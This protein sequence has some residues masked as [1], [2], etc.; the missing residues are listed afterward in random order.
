MG[1]LKQNSYM[2]TR[3]QLFLT[4]AEALMVAEE[5]W[6]KSIHLSRASQI[7]DKDRAFIQATLL[8]A[9]EKSDDAAFLFDVWASATKAAPSKSLKKLV[10]DLMKRT[11]KRWFNPIHQ[12]QG[13]HEMVQPLQGSNVP[14]AIDARPTCEVDR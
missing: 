4:Q 8:I 2:F 13:G 11:A 6:G 12:L 1:L 9:V 3:N 10:K 5:F 14:D 7:T